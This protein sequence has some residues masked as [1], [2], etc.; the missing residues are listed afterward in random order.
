M[1][2]NIKHFKLSTGEEII[3]EVVEWDTIETSAILIRKAMK[4]YD[5]INI[6]NGYKFFSFRPWLSFNDDPNVLQTINSEH[7]VGESSP[8][9]DLLKLY[10]KSLSKLNKFLEEKPISD[11]ID[12]DHLEDLTDDEVHEYIEEQLDKQEAKDSD[13]S[14]N[15]LP[16]PKTF[17]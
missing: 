10:E 7:I 16:F 1:K 5:S 11:P 15:I 12:L 9:P 13:K 2:D 4:L 8:S 17:H 6:R 3:C 14:S